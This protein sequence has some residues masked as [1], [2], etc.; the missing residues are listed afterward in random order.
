MFEEL[1]I[2]SIIAG[3][4]SFALTA[5]LSRCIIPILVARK[6]GQP[7]RKEGP[8]SHFSKQGTPTMGGI[9]FIMAIAIVLTGMTIW[10]AVS[11]KQAELIPMALTMALAVMNG[12]VGF[13]DDY[14][15]LIK[16]DNEGLKAGQKFSLQVL[17]AI[18]YVFLLKFLGHIDTVLHIPFT[19]IEVELGI[20][21][22]VFA[23]ILVVGIVNSVN[24]TDGLDGLAS[25]VTLV[26]A[27]FFA[28]V[29]LTT[30]VPSLGL[31]S[32][33]LIGAMCGFLIY[34]HH[35]AKVFMG[36]TGSLFLGGAVV[37]CAF[38]IN[39]PMIIL[40]AGGIYVFEALSVILQVFWF[41]TFHKRIFKC[42]PVHHHF[43]QC[44][45]SEVK[46]VCVFSCVTVLLCAI[47]W[48]GI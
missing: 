8:K 5:V 1:L 45:W 38:I 46:V 2:E 17:T 18:V 26:V 48:F 24:L 27:V 39:E 25:T 15:K 6:A 19:Q 30:L 12:M 47:A 36:D 20:V 7:I 21:Y 29:A 16:K 42:A 37:G 33:C 44:G 43:E 41:K 14:R 23:V 31:I 9:A 4:S 11:A 40:I 13:V 22:Y 35:P 32:A 34:N 10:Y 28:A 3:V